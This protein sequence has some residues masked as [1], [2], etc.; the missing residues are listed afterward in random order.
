MFTL[1]DFLSQTIFSIALCI[2]GFFCHRA[3]YYVSYINFKRF[4]FHCKVLLL[5][6]S[7]L[8]AL[9]PF[10]KLQILKIYV[11]SWIYKILLKILITL[12]QSYLLCNQ[13]EFIFNPV[14]Y[15]KEVTKCLLNI[16]LE[17]YYLFTNVIMHIKHCLVT[18][19]R[20]I[21]LVLYFSYGFLLNVP[22][23]VLYYVIVMFPLRWL[24]QT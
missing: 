5:N 8:N 16:N 9:Y 11:I 1:P 6:K 7:V 23:F 10:L 15:I 17:D 13:Y 24:Q 21:R 3:T 14:S 19:I 22:C 4:L 20:L 12:F 2:K 18:L